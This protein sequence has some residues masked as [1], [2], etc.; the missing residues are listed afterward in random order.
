MLYYIS[1]DEKIKAQLQAFREALDM[2]LV[3][4]KEE[5]YAH[6]KAVNDTPALP[7]EVQQELKAAR[8]AAKEG[9]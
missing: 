5:G 7:F 8:E 3:G 4:K 2:L 1:Y 9:Q 6:L